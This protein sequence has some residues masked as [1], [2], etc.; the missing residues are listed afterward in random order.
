M[1]A[2]APSEMDTA[3]VALAAGDSTLAN[4]ELL[5][6]RIENTMA[7]VEESKLTHD[8]RYAQLELLKSKIQN[9]AFFQGF[10]SHL[11]I[12]GQI[13]GAGNE[14]LAVNASGTQPSADAAEP[15][16]PQKAL[17]ENQLGKLRAQIAAYRLLARNEPVPATLMAHATHSAL[18]PAYEYSKELESGERLPF[19]VRRQLCSSSRAS[20]L[21]S[22][23]EGARRPRSAYV[24]S[25]DHTADAARHR[26]ARTRKGARESRPQSHSSSY[27]NS[28]L[29]AGKHQRIAA[30][31]SRNRAARF[32]SSQLPS[33]RYVGISGCGERR[34]L[35]RLQCD[36]RFSAVFAATRRSRRRS[37][38]SPIAA[39]SGTLCVRRALWSASRSSRYQA[40]KQK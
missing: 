6:T 36:K 29:I 14:N 24:K 37:I 15:A 34:P 26:S 20:R 7:G 31:A 39:Q 3:S 8:P 27:A 28:L 1:T 38:R 22:A 23:H 30:H 11:H 10:I 2:P 33:L 25:R 40:K 32:A 9:G 4:Q 12:W 19:D 5:I 17:T 13:T 16:A 18:P 35:R 21:F